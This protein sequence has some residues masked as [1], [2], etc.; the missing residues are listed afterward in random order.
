MCF[1]SIKVEFIHIRFLVATLI[2]RNKCFSIRYYEQ[3]VILR[4]SMFLLLYH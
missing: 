3:N 1:W 2:N 4:L